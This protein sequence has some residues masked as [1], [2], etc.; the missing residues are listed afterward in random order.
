MQEVPRDMDMSEDEDEQDA[1][2]RYSRRFK[3]V[4]LRHDIHTL[5]ENFWDRR[6][7][8]DNEYYDSDEGEAQGTTDN[9]KSRHERNYR[10][11]NQVEQSRTASPE[12]VNNVKISQE[13]EEEL[14]EALREEEKE[15][16]IKTEQDINTDALLSS[17][18]KPDTDVE[19][20]GKFKHVDTST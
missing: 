17:D 3:R 8:P 7:V 15:A 5:L 13:E 14:A 12:A 2:D 11:D 6:I 10:E 9:L 1:D 19:M 16:D 20:T 4:P 18:N